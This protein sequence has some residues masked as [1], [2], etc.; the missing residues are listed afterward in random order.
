VRRWETA[1]LCACVGLV[2]VVDQ[3]N[4]DPRFRRNRVRHELLALCADIADRDVVEVLTRQAD[5]LREEGDLLD[6]LASVI[7]PT[8]AAAVAA[9][10]LALARRCV[11]GWL[12][13]EHPPDA[14]TVE[15]VLGVARGEAIGTDAGG[16]RRVERHQ[17][18]LSIVEPEAAGVPA[19]PPH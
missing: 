16:G 8:D 6:D 10:P 11:R 7:D 4:L 5:L 18:R 17:G 2:P 1:A 14:A 3:S 15:R 9:A 12:R 13:Q 19:E